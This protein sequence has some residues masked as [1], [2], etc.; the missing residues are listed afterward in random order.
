MYRGWKACSLALLI[1]LSLPPPAIGH[2]ADPAREGTAV[3]LVFTQLPATAPLPDGSTWAQRMVRAPWGEGSR[4]ARLDPDGTL[5]VLTEGWAG[6]CEPDVSFDG[7]RILFAGKRDAADPWNIFEMLADGSEVRQ[8]T[9]DAGNCRQP[10]WLVTIFTIVDTESAYQIAFVSDHAGE[11]NDIGSRI[12]THLYTCRMDGEGMRR[13]THNVSDDFDPFLMSDGRLLCSS[14]QR[15]DLQHSHMGRVSL[16]ALNV[17]G[18]D[19]MLFCESDDVDVRHMP[20]ETRGGEVVFVETPDEQWPH[21]DGAG[22]L[23]AVQVRRPFHTYRR[24]TEGQDWLY[25][26]PSPFADGALL[27]ARRPKEG[28]GSHGLVR[29]D[30]ATG[31]TTELY[32]DPAYHDFHARALE[33]HL[34]PDGRS[35]IVAE[36]YPTGKLYCMNAYLT[37]PDTDPPLAAGTIHGVRVIEGVPRRTLSDADDI[38]AIIPRRVLGVAPVEADGSFQVEIP[39]SIPI[40]LQTLDEDGMALFTCGWTW[41]QN[42]EFRGCIGCHEDPELVPENKLVDAVVKPGVALLAPPE[43]RGTV[44]FVG[45]VMPIVEA[46]CTSCHD[47]KS[48]SLDLGVAVDGGVN[49]AYRSLVEPLEFAGSSGS[50][51][52]GVVLEG[53]QITPGSARTSPLI[54]WLFHRNTCRPWDGSYGQPLRLPA[55]PPTCATVLTPAERKVFVEWVDLGAQWDADF[56][57]PAPTSDGETGGQR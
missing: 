53:R 27:V 47:G 42:R 32:D 13:I 34:R 1:A 39:A 16:F 15:M 46:K 28:A 24:V 2:F 35:S 43:E 48:H 30:L 54:W 57:P 31:A 36:K 6:A 26:S 5:T 21:G 9:R 19:N 45:D 51:I 44:T 33:P 14:W 11:A 4:L 7:E 52:P 10:V 23:A 25:H 29:M 41:A 38:E 18:A 8:I 55:E 37:A 49:R 3:P 12:G 17:D 56:G 40:Q 50:T 20:C 22:R